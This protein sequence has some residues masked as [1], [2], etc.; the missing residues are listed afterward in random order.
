[1]LLKE[2]VIVGGQGLPFGKL[3]LHSQAGLVHVLDRHGMDFLNERIP[4]LAINEGEEVPRP[5][6]ARNNEVSLQVADAAPFGYGRRS[7]IDEGSVCEQRAFQL[8][9]SRTFQSKGFDLA[10]VR[11]LDESSDGVFGDVRQRLFLFLES[12]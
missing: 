1:M 8:P 4:T 3:L 12:A 5:V 6:L 9:V 11:A 7:C 10:S 2:K